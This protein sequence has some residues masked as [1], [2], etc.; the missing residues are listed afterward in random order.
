[1]TGG[2]VEVALLEEAQAVLRGAPSRRR[3]RPC[4]TA[5]LRFD[6]LRA[7]GVDERDLDRLRAPCG[8]DI[9]ARTP[10]ETAVSV[11]AEIIAERSGRGGGPLSH[12]SGPIHDPRDASAPAAGGARR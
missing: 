2:C 4:W 8:L 6:R 1:M 11:L 10:A 5:A 12:G 3:W 9:G 7:A